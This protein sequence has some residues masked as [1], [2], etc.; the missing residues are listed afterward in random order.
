LM[1]RKVRAVHVKSRARSAV[2]WSRR[3]PHDDTV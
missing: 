1:R 2:S 3:M